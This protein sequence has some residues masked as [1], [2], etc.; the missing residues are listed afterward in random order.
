MI[1]G[2]TLELVLGDVAAQVTDAI[3]NAANSRLAGGG[4]GKLWAHGE[5]ELVI[6]GSLPTPVCRQGG[7]GY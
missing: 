7:L 5:R 3:V 4:G 2:R 1:D 6:G